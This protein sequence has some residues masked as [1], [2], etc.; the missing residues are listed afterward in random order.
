MKSAENTKFI[1]RVDRADFSELELEDISIKIDTGAYTSSIHSHHIAEIIE[2]E[3]KYLEFE[4][5]D[6]EHEQ[7]VSKKIRTKNYE[8]K[9]VKSSNG[10]TEERFFI[11]TTITLFE[12]EYPIKLSLTDRGQMKHPI[13]IGRRF[14]SS[15]FVVNTDLKNL[16]YKQKQKNH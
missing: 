16:S 9:A 14:L 11:E 2:S 13:L 12:Q 15:K 1:G 10:L 6:P 7:Y 3:G 8:V 4:I 5:L